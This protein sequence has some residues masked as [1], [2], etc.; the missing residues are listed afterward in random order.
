MKKDYWL[1][2][3]IS[4]TIACTIFY[5]IFPSEQEVLLENALQLSK[6]N[7][8]DLENEEIIG[9]LFYMMEYACGV[10]G[11]ILKVNPF[12]QP[13]VEAYKRN[14]FHLLGKKGY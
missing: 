13:G 10:S 5:F 11:Y 4:A 7:R 2:L 8:P 9:Q 1:F 3:F 6:E 14:M 12:D